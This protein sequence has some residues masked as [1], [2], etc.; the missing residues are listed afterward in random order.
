MSI[1]RLVTVGSVDDGKSTLIGRLLVDS[2]QVFEDQLESVEK[3]SQQRG[4]DYLDL[5]LLTDGLKA[6]REQGI[7]I[8][9]AYRYFSTPKRK[10]I[11]ADCP[12][13]VQ[14]TRNMVTGASTASLALLLVD[15]RKGLLEQTRR[16]SFISSL[17]G[18]PHL[19]VC[20]NKM[21]LVDYAQEDFE[22]VKA[23]FEDF[24]TKLDIKDVTFIPIS[25]LKGDNV[26]SPSDKMSWY[27]G[28]PLID[29]LEE[30]HIASD[31]NHIDFRFPVQMVIRPHSESVTDYRA[32]AGQVASGSIKT[33]DT[34]RVLPSGFESKVKAIECGG[35]EIGEAVASMSVSIR[36]E[37]E[38]DISRGNMICRPNNQPAA[39]QDLDV[40]TC[41]LSEKPMDPKRKYS[42]MHTTNSARCLV[43]EVL[44]K[45]DVNT[46]SRE[47]FDGS[48]KM[49]EVGRMKLRTTNPLFCD[50]YRR[51]RSTGSFILIDEA[52]NLTVGAAMLTEAGR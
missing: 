42:L 35:V 36:L 50:P 24:S 15:A 25:A 6:E 27:K 4:D 1:L 9:V 18:I 40:L 39:L 29:H 32:Y 33:G 28:R 13:H 20:V 16:H 3:T 38:I 44:Y 51:N 47:D 7:T 5:A 48:L 52:D 21:D 45:I 37:D 31:R 23:Q 41:W 22:R 30:V 46:L 14:Y 17:L 34:I 49:N 12:G 11:M 43:K 10:F 26:V 8:D 19:V 2:K